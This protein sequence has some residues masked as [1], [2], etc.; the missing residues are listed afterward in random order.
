MTP[1]DPFERS[2][3][4]SVASVSRGARVPP[5]GSR[6]SMNRPFRM[7]ALAALVAGGG[8]CPAGLGLGRPD[9][10][11]E[12]GAGPGVDAGDAGRDAGADAGGDAGADGG[13]AFPVPPLV[14]N[15][16]ATDPFIRTAPA[17]C[18]CAQPFFENVMGDGQ[19]FEV[20]DSGV[21][22]CSCPSVP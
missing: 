12:A 1:L 22:I 17:W 14:A 5:R 3:A 13:S 16:G 9:S 18:T 11:P 20:T 6:P 8:G 21:R 10:G 4:T 2:E 7:L 19:C 15:Q